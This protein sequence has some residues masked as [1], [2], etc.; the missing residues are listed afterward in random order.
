MNTTIR[1]RIK[2]E[3][4]PIAEKK[5]I[6]FKGSLIAKSFTDIIYFDEENQEYYVHYFIIETSRRKEVTDY[7]TLCIERDSLLDTVTLLY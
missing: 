5:I 2:K 7:I 4:D 3:L 6:R 1:F